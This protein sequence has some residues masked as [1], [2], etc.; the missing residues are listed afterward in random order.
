[1]SGLACKTRWRAAPP[2]PTPL[3]ISLAITFQTPLCR[4]DRLLVVEVGNPPSSE[5]L[6]EQGH[7]LARHDG[8]TGGGGHPRA[9][10]GA[11]LVQEIPTPSNQGSTGAPR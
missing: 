6:T 8:L 5:Q 2:V 10:I 4:L 7:V 3:P 9:E 11:R 1:M